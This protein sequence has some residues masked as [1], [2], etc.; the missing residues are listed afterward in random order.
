M[1]DETEPRVDVDDGATS[2]KGEKGVRPEA[3]KAKAE[4]FAPPEEKLKVDY[5]EFYGPPKPAGRIEVREWSA[6]GDFPGDDK[7]R[8]DKADAERHR[9][10][11]RPPTALQVTNDLATT[12]EDHIRQ[13]KACEL[14]GIIDQQLHK[15]I[16][17]QDA[18]SFA[19]SP[20][21]ADCT[22]APT[23]RDLFDVSTKEV[24]KFWAIV[25]EDKNGNIDLVD[26]VSAYIDCVKPSDKNTI[27]LDL[28]DTNSNGYAYKIRM[29][30]QDTV[31][32][33]KN[34]LFEPTG[35]PIPQSHPERV[36]EHTEH[37][38][39]PRPRYGVEDCFLRVSSLGMLDDDATL[40]SY[41][42]GIEESKKYIEFMEI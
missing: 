24:A 15:K 25:D 31:L 29:S 5:L 14:F 8:R 34:K 10:E 1:A 17:K 18:R 27:I 30:R 26:F 42:I 22:D 9:F 3:L 13:N 38:I 23:W 39:A 12:E 4:F 28:Q 21:G 37:F 36:R 20:E 16:N 19:D 2:H 35:R 6:V 33:L 11:R 32:D 40:E 7:K 41:G